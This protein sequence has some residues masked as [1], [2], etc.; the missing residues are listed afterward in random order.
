M[1][2]ADEL[3]DDNFVRAFIKSSIKEALE[4]KNEQ[5]VFDEIVRTINEEAHVRDILVRVDIEWV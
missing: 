1:K 3:I 5:F 4:M 2:R